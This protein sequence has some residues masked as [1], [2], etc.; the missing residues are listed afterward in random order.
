MQHR[1]QIDALVANTLHLTSWL[2]G[3]RIALRDLKPEN[4]L[5]VGKGDD[6]PSFL[7]R[8][9][10]F[11]LGLIDREPATAPRGGGADRGLLSAPK[12]GGTP[13][14]ATPSHFVAFEP[15]KTIY[16]DPFEILLEQDW[17]AAIAICF[18]TVTGQHLWDGTAGLFS[19][20]VETLASADPGD[21]ECFA[22]LFRKLS[23]VFWSNARMEFRDKLRQHRAILGKVKVDLSR[24]CVETL[25]RRIDRRIHLLQGERRAFLETHENLDVVARHLGLTEATAEQIRLL[26]TTWEMDGATDSK[27]GCRFSDRFRQLE[28]LSQNIETLEEGRGLLKNWDTGV[29]LLPLLAVLFAHCL[30]VMYKGEWQGLGRRRIDWHEALMDEPSYTQTL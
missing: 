13:L 12:P 7:K 4:L 20:L 10:W 21:S 27:G 23:W 15:L 19:A 18:R 2:Y 24:Q 26:R 14:Y 30:S 17:Y 16:A 29:A 22:Q 3:R 9:E 1:Q 6:F 8:R 25:N 11:R 5:V 28:G